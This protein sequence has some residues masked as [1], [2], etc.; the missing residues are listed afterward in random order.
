MCV[1]VCF[2]VR[3]GIHV[4]KAKMDG[5]RNSIPG[6]IVQ[7]TVINFYSVRTSQFQTE[8]NQKP[9]IVPINLKGCE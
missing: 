9:N 3:G 2:I 7:C 5:L 6:F 4:H 1:C 8:S